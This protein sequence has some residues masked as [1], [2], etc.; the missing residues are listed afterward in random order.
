[1]AAH[2]TNSSTS[3]GASTIWEGSLHFL[4]F[5]PELR[6]KIY[7]LALPY[8][9]YHSPQ[10]LIE[11]APSVIAVT[12]G[13]LLSKHSFG[14]LKKPEWE[15]WHNVPSDTIALLRVNKQIS[16]E[17][18]AVIYRD[19]IFDIAICSSGTSFFGQWLP[20][21][22]FLPFPSSSHWKFTRH[23]VFDLRFFR[24]NRKMVVRWG[25]GSCDDAGVLHP[26]YGFVSSRD[27]Y[28]YIRISENFIA[29]CFELAKIPELETLTL[30]LPCLGRKTGNAYAHINKTYMSLL[31]H[32][33]LAGIKP[34]AFKINLAPPSERQ[35]Q[36]QGKKCLDY[37]S[38]LQE[39][40]STWEHRHVYAPHMIEWMAVRER[41]ALLAPSA[42]LRGFLYNVWWTKYFVESSDDRK[43]QVAWMARQ[44]V[45]HWI[46]GQASSL[47]GEGSD[48]VGQVQLA[49]EESDTAKELEDG[50]LVEVEEEAI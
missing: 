31:T 42:D 10:A 18:R 46:Q 21:T 49:T 27:Q 33:A 6:N 9:A 16:N 41:A 48:D 25:Y 28:E 7:R 11:S 24:F 17:A 19:A 50:R 30:N 40:W 22:H 4:K 37:R 32:L 38:A 35:T 36:C 8:Q 1:M 29:A 45:E 26:S 14:G 23:W 2:A 34:K 39:V 15:G 43:F 3:S 44:F 20:T 47:A 12:N 5:P 13:Q